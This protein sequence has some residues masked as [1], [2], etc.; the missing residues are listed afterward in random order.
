MTATA[1]SEHQPAGKQATATFGAGC[2]WCVEAVFQQLDGVLKVESGYTGGHVKNPTYREVCDGTTGHA[3]VCRI[4]Y[5]P[6]KLRYE[7]LL[8][9]FWKTHDPTTPNQQGYDIGTQYRS[10]IFYHDEEQKRLAEKYKK[11]LNDAKAF[12]KPIVTEI[13]A[14]VEFYKA[15]DY[16][17]NYFNTNPGDRY[18]RAIIQPK[19]DKVR[20]VFAEQLKKE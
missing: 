10:A 3:E 12:A 5:N 17:Q 7:Q 9:V 20:K 16:H 19:I 4:T 14:A 13:T 8:E 1:D 6:A 11:E 2:F 15:E 18:C